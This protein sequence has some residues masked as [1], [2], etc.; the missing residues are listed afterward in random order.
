VIPF[1]SLPTPV[2]H[3]VVQKF[4]MQLETQ[5][6]ERGVTFDLSKDAIAWLADKGYDEHMGARPLARV[7]QEHIKKELANEVLFG[8]LKKGGTVKVTVEKKNDGTTGLKL[9]AIPDEVPV[10]PARKQADRKTAKAK[11]AAKGRARPAR[12]DAPDT[13][14][15]DGPAEPEAG[16]HAAVSEREPKSARKS[17]S[18]VPKVPRRK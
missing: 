8:K 13:P 1:G 2:I 5:L 4:V 7:I 3:Q 12:R 18:S 15:E 10:K 6:A 17:G 14:P 11:P 16:A 9:D